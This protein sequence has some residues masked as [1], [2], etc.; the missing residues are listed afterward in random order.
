[1]KSL[2]KVMK[3]E[4]LEDKSADQI[5]DIWTKHFAEKVPGLTKCGGGALP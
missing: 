3:L 1:M 2:E 4:L 5:A